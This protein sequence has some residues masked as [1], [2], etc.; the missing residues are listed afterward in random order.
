L[1]SKVQIAIL[2]LWL[3]GLTP[4]TEA[5][6]SLD[7]AITAYEK[8]DV[9]KALELLEVLAKT[10][11]KQA[12]MN[13]AKVEMRSGKAK[14][15]LRAAERL[16]ELYPDDPDAHLTLGMAYLTMMGE[17][18]MFR[19]VS[20]AKQARAGWEKAIALDPNHIGGLYSLFSYYA[21]APK[22]GGGDIEQAHLMQAR[23]AAID[24]GYGYLS[25]ALLQAKDENFDLAEANLL[26]A[27]SALDTAG[28]YFTLAQ[29]YLDRE[30]FEDALDAIAKFPLKPSN[31]WDPDPPARYLVIANAQAGLGDIV[32][33]RAAIDAG[34]AEKPGKRLHE[35]FENIRKDL[36]IQHQQ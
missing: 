14:N 19:L 23:L 10:D 24:A 21:N 4:A 29:F 32:A 7:Q 27:A 28:V 25:I 1:N 15:A 13:L 26:K 35:F 31:F 3:A 11:E 2:F 20:M 30:R 34:L 6:S 17:V 16:V 12:L 18:N 8:R 36:R 9:R 5:A 22:V 33:A